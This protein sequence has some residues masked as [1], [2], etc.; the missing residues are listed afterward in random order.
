[1]KKYIVESSIVDKICDTSELST[2]VNNKLAEG[3]TLV[4]GI[5][6]LQ[7]SGDQFNGCILYSQAL[8]KE[9]ENNQ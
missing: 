8:V 9:D 1:M 7:L 5:Q 6:T 2:K 3:F 4:G